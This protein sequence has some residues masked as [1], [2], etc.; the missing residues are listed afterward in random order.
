MNTITDKK[1]VEVNI[2]VVAPTNDKYSFYTPCFISENDL[3]ERDIFV[4]ELKDVLEAGYDVNSDAYQYCSL[5][6]IQS[7]RVESVVLVAKRSN[8]T[9]LN[10]V[11]QSRNSKYY[12]ITIDSKNV[13]DVLLLSSGLNS[14]R[15]TKLI[16]FSTDDYI[17]SELIGLKNVVLLFQGTKWLWASGLNLTWDNDDFVGTDA[18]KYME[19]AWI[20]RCGGIFPSQIQWLEKELIGIEPEDLESTD[21]DYNY[22]ST[23]DEANV[24]WGSGT[25]CDGEWIDHRVFEDWLKVAIQRNV[26]NLLK[27]SLKVSSTKDGA[28]K[29]SLRVKEVL[30]FGVKQ[31]GI[32]SYK[33]KEPKINRVERSCSIDFEYTRQHAI[34]GVKT[35]K[36]SLHA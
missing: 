33:I 26:W 23:V 34:I 27:T 32:I 25:T 10:A 14:L 8:E 17:S 1:P 35:I 3:V 22:Y 19:A 21:V 2:E 31:N 24:T 13:E 28:D 18:Y 20:S 30:D 5:A 12:F 15:L 11:L 9:Y 29:I 4:S 6:F 7:P 16:F 36:G